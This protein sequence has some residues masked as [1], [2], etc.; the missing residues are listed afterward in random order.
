MS[1]QQLTGH[2]TFATWQ[3]DSISPQEASPRLARA[4]IVNAFTGGIEASATDCAYSL[5]YLTE[6]TG[7]FNGLQVFSGSL[8]GRTGGFVLEER[9]TFGADGTVHCTLEV[10]ENSGTGELTGLRG[11][12]GFVAVHGESTVPYTFEYRLGQEPLAAS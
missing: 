6:K 10:V 12:G 2:F 3:E 8:D 5:V 9:G 7:V 1:P 4:T 11:T